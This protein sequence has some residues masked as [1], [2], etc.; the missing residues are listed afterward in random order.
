MLACIVTTMALGFLWWGLLFTKPWMKAMGWDG[1][2]KEELK[3]KG[4]SGGPGYAMSMLGAAVG[5]LALW[6]IF[7]RSPAGWEDF[8]K[9]GWGVILGLL[10][11]I[12]FYVPA[13]ATTIFFEDRNRVLWGID[14]SYRLVV[15]A[16]WGLWVGLLHV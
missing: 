14:I 8:G 15:F 2:S 9:A 16:L 7:D 13:T 4:G 6:F 1:L 12:A 5:G 3:E 11:G 10:V